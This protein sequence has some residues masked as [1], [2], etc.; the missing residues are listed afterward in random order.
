MEGGVGGEA[1][2]TSVLQNFGRAK[3][4]G[5]QNKVPVPNHGKETEK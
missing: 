1:C 5:E 2:V 3:N 4:G